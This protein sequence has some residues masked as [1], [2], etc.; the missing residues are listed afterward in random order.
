M[1]AAPPKLRRALAAAS[2]VLLCWP[3]LGQ[4]AEPLAGLGLRQSGAELPGIG[5]VLLVLVFTLAVGVAAI[6]ALRRF[7]AG[8][9]RKQLGRARVAAQ[10][11]VSGS[12]RLHFIDFDDTT[13]VV[14][15]GRSGVAI[16][17]VKRAVAEPA[18][19]AA[20]AG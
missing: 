2:C 20:D 18:G 12:L 1:S 5:R 19:S 8:P 15:E 4:D 11:P 14:A 16:A 17:E 3:C 6:Y 10:L 13:L 7:W 9:L